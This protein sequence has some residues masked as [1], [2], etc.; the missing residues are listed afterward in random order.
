MQNL[1]QQR[2]AARVD[3]SVGDIEPVAVPGVGDVVCGAQV[4]LELVQLALGIAAQDAQRVADVHGVHADQQIVVL[5]VPPGQLARPAALTGDAVAG[6]LRTGGRIDRVADLVPA[7]RAGGD[8]EDVLKPLL[9][10]ELLH[11]H[12]AHRAAADIAVANK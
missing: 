10:H 12:L 3:L 4:F 8:G 2:P 11:D 5:V 9:A 1:F 7:G 6:Q